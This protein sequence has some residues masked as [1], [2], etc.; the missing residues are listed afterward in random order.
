MALCRPPRRLPSPA[1]GSPAGSGRTRTRCR[2][3]TASTF[4]GAACFP[5]SQTRTSTSRPGRLRDGRCASRA[6]RPWKRRSRGYGMGSGRCAKAAGSAAAAGGMQGGPS[7]RAARRWTR[8]PA[9]C[10]WRCSRTT[11]TRSGSTRPRSRE[12]TATWRSKGASSSGMPRASRPGSSARRP[13]G[14]SATATSRSRTRSTSTRCA[15]ACGWRPRGGLP[16]STTRTAGSERCGTGRR[17]PPR[18]RCRYGSGSHFQLTTSAGS[19]SWAS[20]A[21][22]ATGCSESAT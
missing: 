15:R 21:V 3:P 13:A 5:D 1:T 10:R 7:G 17:S 22:S 11:R 8:W 9:R 12:L 6:S 2:P 14:A 4:V 16:P 20:G 18:G 19:R